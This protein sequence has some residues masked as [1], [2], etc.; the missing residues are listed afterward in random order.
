MKGHFGIGE[1]LLEATT[2]FEQ[3]ILHDIAGVST[4]NDLWVQKQPYHSQQSGPMT[5]DEAILGVTVLA[6]SLL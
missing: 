6:P 3:C 2:R 1:V 4:R 5:R